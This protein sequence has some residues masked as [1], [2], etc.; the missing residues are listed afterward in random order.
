MKSIQQACVYE[1]NSAA[2]RFKMLG[3]IKHGQKCGTE[4]DIV[5]AEFC[6]ARVNLL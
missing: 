6:I 2:D 4:A 5:S 3:V 1:S